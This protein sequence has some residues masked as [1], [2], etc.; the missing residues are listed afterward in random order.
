MTKI[1]NYLFFLLYS[2]V[3]RTNSV[4]PVFSGIGLISY[5]EAMIVLICFVIVEIILK[6]SLI[7]GYKEYFI[8][9]AIL[10]LILNSFYFYNKKKYIQ[11][12][13]NLE[14]LTR[15]QKIKTWHIVVSMFLIFFILSALAIIKKI[16]L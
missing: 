6:Q 16:F 9:G 14:F 10:L 3:K 8:A 11:I 4:D 7:T 1:Y 15:G 5:F 12:L 13:N 2:S